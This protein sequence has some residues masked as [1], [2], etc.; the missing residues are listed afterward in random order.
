MANTI[1]IILLT[2][3]VTYCLIAIIQLAYR[4]YKEYKKE[5]SE[6]LTEILDLGALKNVDIS[7]DEIP[8]QELTGRKY[9]SDIGAKTITLGISPDDSRQ[10]Q[11]QKERDTYGFDETDVWDLDSTMIELLYERVMMFNEI[12]PMDLEHHTIEINGVEKSQKEWIDELLN[13]CEKAI[14]YTDY[15]AFDETSRQQIWTI[16]RELSRFML[17]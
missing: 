14:R 15:N 10:E 13:L 2:M 9:I 16:W 7:E 12:C 11:W 5:K 6:A 4:D 8:N 1:T 17:W 3:I